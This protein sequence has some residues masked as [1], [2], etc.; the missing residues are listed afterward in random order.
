MQSV[1]HALIGL[2]ETRHHLHLQDIFKRCSSNLTSKSKTLSLHWKPPRYRPV[3]SATFWRSI[4]ATKR[5][6]SKGGE[7]ELVFD[8][9]LIGVE[10]T[11]SLRL[12]F[13]IALPGDWEGRAA[14][15]YC[16][17][18]LQLDDNFTPGWWAVLPSPAR[19]WWKYYRLATAWVRRPIYI[20]GEWIREPNF[21]HFQ[22][23][24]GY[25][26]QSL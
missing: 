19:K 25:L 8:G 24:T 16:I 18:Y 9:C 26:S 14:N 12:D 17:W 10:V 22:K 21:A 11:C 3:V 5:R 15:L 1:R 20:K 13:S 6:A 4:F 7:A 2:V 23:F